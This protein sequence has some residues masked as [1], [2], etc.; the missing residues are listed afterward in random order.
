MANPSADF[1]EALHTNTDVSVFAGSN[2]GDTSP[3]HTE[4]EGKQEEEI[5]AI[6][7]KLGTGSGAV[8]SAGEVLVGVGTGSSDWTAQPGSITTVTFAPEFDNGD[9]SGATT[10]DWNNGQKQAG[11]LSASGTLSFTDPPGPGNFLLRLINTGTPAHPVTWPSDVFFPGGINP[12][13]TAGSPTIDIVSFYFD[14][15]GSYYGQAGLNF[16]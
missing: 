6:Q 10:V 16:Q 1:P 8:P 3:K 5:L 15:T 9:F 14:G 2:L 11:F 13:L 12:A 7:T 4:L